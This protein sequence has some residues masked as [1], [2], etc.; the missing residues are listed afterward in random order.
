MKRERS[1]SQPLNLIFL[2]TVVVA[3]HCSILL[4]SYT[5]TDFYSDPHPTSPSSSSR[6]SDIDRTPI[7]RSSHTYSPRPLRLSSSIRPSCGIERRC[8][9][10]FTLITDVLIPDS[11]RV[12]VSLRHSTVPLLRHPS[13]LGLSYFIEPDL[14]STSALH[15]ARAD[16]APPRLCRITAA[17][18]C[19]SASALL[20]R[21]LGRLQASFCVRDNGL[22][23]RP[24]CS[25]LALLLFSPTARP[26]PASLQLRP[27]HLSRLS[28]SATAQVKSTCHHHAAR[29]RRMTVAPFAR[30][31]CRTTRVGC[32]DADKSVD[33]MC[34][35]D[36]GIS[37]RPRRPRRLLSH[38]DYLSLTPIQPPFT[39]THSQCLV[40]I[41][42]HPVFAF[43]RATS[44]FR[45]IPPPLGASACHAPPTRRAPPAT[46]ATAAAAIFHH[47]R[48]LR[49]LPMPVD[50]LPRRPA[51]T[52]LR[53]HPHPSPGC[54]T[55][56]PACPAA[57][58]LTTR[59]TAF[60]AQCAYLAAALIRPDYHQLTQ[61]LQ[62]VF[63]RSRRLRR[64]LD[65]RNL[66]VPPSTVATALGATGTASGQ[67]ACVT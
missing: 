2:L 39:A 34:S 58:S 61:Y 10:P 55:P 60:D 5:Q 19:H 42:S 43:S 67:R 20:V 46:C 36:V 23:R 62:P 6:I 47:A 53:V 41:L 40:P 31:R 30:P 64:L 52:T 8:S 37:R 66:R 38:L 33:P 22:D 15:Y 63:N 9:I 13:S 56:P 49:L 14:P 3:A 44:N 25:C 28:A 26:V 51:L 7:K 48:P 11:E 29:T 45:A 59:S 57:L 17:I 24:S 35:V 27:R 18:T 21:V 65:A 4:S 32:Y 54:R 1:P 12:C 50:H 16:A